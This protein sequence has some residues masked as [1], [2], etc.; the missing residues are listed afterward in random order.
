MHL[1][2]WCCNAY[3]SSSNTALCMSIVVM[4]C[5]PNIIFVV[6]HAAFVSHS[7]VRLL[8]WKQVSADFYVKE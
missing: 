5:C 4:L 8:F 2:K 3:F 6:F 1:C 7:N